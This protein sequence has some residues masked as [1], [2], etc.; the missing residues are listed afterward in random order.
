VKIVRPKITLI[1]ENVP[2]I[3]IET[4]SGEID[5]HNFPDFVG[6]KYS[7][8]LISLEFAEGI[9]GDFLVGSN[10]CKK[11]LLFFVNPC[12]SAR[13]ERCNEEMCLLDL[14]EFYLN[15]LGE[16]MFFKFVFENDSVFEIECDDFYV[17]CFFV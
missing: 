16:K 17:E 2:T 12:I 8:N 11:T 6:V 1:E 10:V 15:R 13:F 7:N 4:D 3:S 14:S 5:L 9:A